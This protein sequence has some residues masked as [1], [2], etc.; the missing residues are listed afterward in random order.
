MSFEEH[1]ALPDGFG[2]ILQDCARALDKIKRHVPDARVSC[3]LGRISNRLWA[4][5]EFPHPVE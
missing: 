3:E 1:F 5:S 4:M 2:D